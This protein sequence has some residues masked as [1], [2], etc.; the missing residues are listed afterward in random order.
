M[1]LSTVFWNHQVADNLQ[2]GF[3]IGMAIE[4]KTNGVKKIRSASSNDSRISPTDDFN[5]SG[6]FNQ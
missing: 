5:A 1:D 2:G 4:D 6:E 3:H